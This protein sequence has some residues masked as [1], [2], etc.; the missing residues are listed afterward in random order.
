[1]LD[2]MP[3]PRLIQHEWTTHGTCSGLSADQYFGVIRRAYNSIKIPPPL[4]SPTRTTTRSAGEIK[5]MFLDANPGMSSVAVA[6]SCH[7]RYL[8]AV[9][10]CLGKNLQ[11]TACQA[12][13]D[14][15]ANSIRIPAAQ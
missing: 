6:V 10:F 7:N 13:R 12:V 9:E 1:M 4:V 2:I 8:S 11:P 14:C 5:Q 3:D 15:T